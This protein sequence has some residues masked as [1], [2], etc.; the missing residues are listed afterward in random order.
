LK[1]FP[2][3]L[4][5]H[6]KYFFRGQEE[7]PSHRSAG[8]IIG[9]ASLENAAF[10]ISEGLA[11]LWTGSTGTAVFLDPNHPQSMHQRYLRRKAQDDAMMR[12]IIS[13]QNQ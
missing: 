4:R 1:T 8:S 10:Y 6:G 3:I 5:Q 12:A 13:Q 2:I 9:D 7:R 11:D